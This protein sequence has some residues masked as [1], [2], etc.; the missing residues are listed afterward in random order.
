MKEEKSEKLNKI[1]NDIGSAVIAF[2][3]GVDSSFLLYAAHKIKKES[4]YAVTIQT[5]YMPAR[6]ID[7]AVKFTEKFGINHKIIKTGIPEIIKQNPV[8]RCYYC[9]KELFNHII[10]FAKS[11]AYDVILDGSNADDTKDYRPGMKALNELGV[12]S[13][14]LEAGLTKNEIRECLY[15]EG[16]DIWDYPA[17]ACMLTRIPYN[18]EIK[19]ETLIMIEEAENF[20][21]EKGYKGARVRIHD[22]V[23]RIECFP[24]FI[25]KMI[26]SAEREQITK[27][28][29]KIGFKHIALDMEGYRTGS[30]NPEK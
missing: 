13:P 25:E 23:A 15:K 3:G 22:D 2:S 30:M 6:E 5:P 14:L 19:H 10:D 4:I 21:F 18:V 9:K 7:D 24:E 1:L 16:L 11:G 12:R 20:L 17:M 26:T 29:K 28:F 27:R 8:E